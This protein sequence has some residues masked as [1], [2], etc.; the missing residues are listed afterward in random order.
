M[1]TPTSSAVVERILLGLGRTIVGL[2][3]GIVVLGA[4]I[5]SFF[6]CCGWD[7][8]TWV[9][10]RVSPHGPYVTILLVWPAI[11]ALCLLGQ[12]LITEMANA[13]GWIRKRL[14]GA[15]RG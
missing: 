7:G 11:G 9:D 10:P 14:S 15:R 2:A 12:G 1:T 4:L 3:F 8:S 5:L 13:L 6:A